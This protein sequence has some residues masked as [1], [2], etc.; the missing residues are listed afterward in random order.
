MTDLNSLPSFS[1]DWVGGDM[2]GLHALSAV[3]RRVAEDISGAGHVLSRQVSAVA[4]SGD[5]QG[6]AADSF[7]TAWDRDAKATA[8]LAD[9]WRTIAGIVAAL[10]WDLAAVENSLEALA[11]QL[12]KKGVAVDN[13]TGAPLTDV[14]ASG[15]ACSGPHEAAVRAKLISDYM[16]QSDELLLTAEAA[17]THAVGRLQ[18]VT[19]EMLPPGTDWGQ[20]ANDLDSLRGIWAAPT[21]YRK[22]LTE[23]LP[24]MNANVDSAERMALKELIEIR[25]E[26][27]NAALLSKET[28]GNVTGALQAQA[29]IRGKI[30]SVPE[31]LLTKG[32]AG[33]AEGLG[34]TGALEGTIKAIPVI[35]AVAGAGITI[36]Q[37]LGNHESVTHSLADGVGSNALGY[38]AATGGAALGVTVGGF[39][40]GEVGGVALGTVGGIA[41]AVGVG[42]FAH[43]AFQEN[44]PQDVHQHGVLG[45]VGHGI[46][47]TWDKTRHDLAHY[48]DDINPF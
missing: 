2:H 25:K 36:A 35:G 22:L 26:V 38:V 10:A 6:K 19:K 8:M 43:N 1:Y 4:S 23:K 44:W 14:T 32:A 27:G 7:S 5:W 41:A 12:E 11:G 16:V 31:N 42:D 30:A 28:R 37:D 21:E 46:A 13:R 9:S 29:S 40:G 15:R 3:C 17:R 34:A 39:I 24:E 18:S 45:G 33:D 47:D 20:L 48:F